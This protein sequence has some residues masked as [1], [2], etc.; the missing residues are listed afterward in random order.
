M[1]QNQSS[2]ASGD[3]AL[4][5]ASHKHCDSDLAE[6]MT[7]LKMFQEPHVR[8]DAAEAGC[9]PSGPPRGAI[10]KGASRVFAADL[11]LPLPQNKMPLLVRET[12]QAKKLTAKSVQE[13]AWGDRK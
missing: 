13:K 2:P 11:A 9:G 4:P 8:T 1:L 7:A 10:F 12:L 5:S 3:P 6:R